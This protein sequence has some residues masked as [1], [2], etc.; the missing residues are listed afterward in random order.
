[1]C[2]I[3]MVGVRGSKPCD[4]HI[5]ILSIAETRLENVADFFLDAADEVF[6]CKLFRYCQLNKFI[7]SRGS[8]C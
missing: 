8:R 5:Q 1:M 4:N 3:L 6:V 2:T 7:Q